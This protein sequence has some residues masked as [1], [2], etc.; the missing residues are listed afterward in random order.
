MEHHSFRLLAA[1]AVALLALA[2]CTTTVTPVQGTPYSVPTDRATL[3]VLPSASPSPTMRLLSPQP[4]ASRA[5]AVDP[6]TGAATSSQQT[7]AHVQLAASAALVTIRFVNAAPQSITIL[8]ESSGA[9]LYHVSSMFG[10]GHPQ[11]DEGFV[12]VFLAPLHNDAS[13]QLILGYGPCRP[14][15]TGASQVLVISMNADHHV[16]IEQLQLDSLADAVAEVREGSLWVSQ[17]AA[18]RVT[19]VREFRWDAVRQE[20]V[21]R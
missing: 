2:A 6:L 16:V 5:G 3:A 1:M 9:D 11:A 21:E 13:E 8:D 18:G 7:F 19:S 20:L 15:C 12:Q 10:P 4:F 14:G 17:W